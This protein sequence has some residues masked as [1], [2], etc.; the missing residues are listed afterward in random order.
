MKKTAFLINTSRGQVV[1][2]ETLYKALKQGWIAGAGLDVTI[3]EPINP[4]NPLLKLDNL[5]IT[6]HIGYY[7]EGCIE[8]VRTKAARE[9][10]RV[11]K[12]RSPRPIAFINPQVKKR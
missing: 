9:I 5:I 3:E 2:K 1:N 4:N 8:E 10:V 11:L 7:S 6:N 12:G